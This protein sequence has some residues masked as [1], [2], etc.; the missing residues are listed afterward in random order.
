MFGI[1]K[2][3]LKLSFSIMLAQEI[4]RAELQKLYGKEIWF[5]RCDIAPTKV[6]LV[7]KTDCTL[8]ARLTTGVGL[9]R[10]S[11]E[12]KERYIGITALVGPLGPLY[13]PTFAEDK[14]R[15]LAKVVASC[16][17]FSKETSCIWWLPHYISLY[18]EEEGASMGVEKL[19]IY[20]S[21]SLDGSHYD[22]NSQNPCAD[23]CDSQTGANYARMHHDMD[24]VE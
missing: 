7:K 14:R 24:H 13:S 10:V 5:F 11:T 2:S 15:K 16:R 21:G 1:G 20:E 18:I 6:F 4:L 12:T 23:M 22:L 8:M 19:L 3:S 17:L 9:T